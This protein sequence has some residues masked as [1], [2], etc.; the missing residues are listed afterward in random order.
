M[1]K[2]SA[3]GFWRVC[4]AVSVER[5]LRLLWLLFEENELCVV[6][7]AGRAG[8]QAPVASVQLNILHAMGMVRYRRRKMNVIYRAEADSQRPGCVELLDALKECCQKDVPLHEVIRQVTAF[9]HER[10]IEI[11]R[12]LTDATGSFAQLQERTGITS[13]ALSRHLLKLEARKVVRWDGKM[14]RI[15]Q[16]ESRLGRVL[17][18]IVCRKEPD[19]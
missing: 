9:T 14:Y 13:S 18:E 2:W 12:S 11:V 3:V 15:A 10:R 1:G 6:E 17:L 19:E 4:R 7:L 8:I 5:R 16:P